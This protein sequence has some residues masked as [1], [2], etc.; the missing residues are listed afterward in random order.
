MESLVACSL[1]SLNKNLGLR[2]TGVGGALRRISG[3]I[4]IMINKQDVMEAA[5]SLQVCAGQ[6]AGTEAVIHTVHDIF[7]DH[8]TEAVLLINAENSFNAINRKAMLHNLSVTCPIIFTYISNCY[9]RPARLFGIRGTKILSK[10]ET[11]QGDPT[12]FESMVSQLHH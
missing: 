8:T 1:I 10:E 5:D 12:L 2:P 3:K 11:I 9:N 7:K 6:R 4:L